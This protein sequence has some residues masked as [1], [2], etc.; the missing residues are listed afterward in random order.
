MATVYLARDLRHDRA[1]ALKVFRQEL[2]GSLGA[3]WFLREI[4]IVA[5]LHHPHILPLYSSGEAAGRLFY[6]MPYVEGESLRGTLA[7]EGRLPVPLALR[8]ALEVALAWC[9]EQQVDCIILWPTAQSRSLYQ[10]HGFEDAS[11]IMSARLAHL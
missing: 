7:R 1:V 11:D 2:A 10:R 5:P 3:E 4:A 9:R 8:I 6:V